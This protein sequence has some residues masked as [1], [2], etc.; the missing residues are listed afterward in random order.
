MVSLVKNTG[1]KFAGPHCTI[2]ISL[3]KKDIDDKNFK[4]LKNIKIN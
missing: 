4:Y 2:H 3:N 1:I